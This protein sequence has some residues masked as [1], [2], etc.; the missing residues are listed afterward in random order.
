MHFM[1]L[2]DTFTTY[3]K[4]SKEERLPIQTAASTIFV[5]GKGTI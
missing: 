5:E 2:R 4:F 1:P 3:H